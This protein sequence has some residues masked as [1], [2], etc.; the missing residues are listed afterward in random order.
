MLLAERLR[1][2]LG[3]TSV[4]GLALRAEHRPELASCAVAPGGGS[5]AGVPAAASRPAWLLPRPQ[6]LPEVGGRPQRDGPLLLLAG[7]ERIESGWWDADEPGAV[8]D[9]R[10]DYFVALSPRREWLWIYRCAAGWF[11]HGL[12]A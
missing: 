7:P 9:V 12:Y 10:R 2:R 1:A 11:L 3:E 6:A 4:H 8:G 5:S